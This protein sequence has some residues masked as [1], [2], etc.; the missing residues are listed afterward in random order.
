MSNRGKYRAAWHRRL[1]GFC[2]GGGGGG[3]G[4]ALPSSHVAPTLLLRGTA[5]EIDAYSL[6]HIACLCNVSCRCYLRFS[7]VPMVTVLSSLL[8]LLSGQGGAAVVAATRGMECAPSWQY[9]CFVMSPRSCLGTGVCSEPV[10]KQ[11]ILTPRRT[12]SCSSSRSGLSPSCHCCCRGVQVVR[13]MA[14]LRFTW[15]GLVVC[16]HGSSSREDPVCKLPRR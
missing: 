10:P 9:A 7:A 13:L 6:P 3:G 8:T 5:I 14:G 1:P 16:H 11:Y 12:T 2:G 4:F 15:I